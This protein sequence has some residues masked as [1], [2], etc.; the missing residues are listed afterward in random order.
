MIGFG[1]DN[2]ILLSGEE[3][4]AIVIEVTP[5]LIKYQK[6]SNLNGP[7]YTIF[8]KDVFL[9]K[10][11]NG[12]KDLFSLKSKNIET[13]EYFNQG[14]DAADTLHSA[15]PSFIGGIMFNWIGI[16]FIH[17]SDANRLPPVYAQEVNVMYQENTNFQKG[18]KQQARRKNIKAVWIGG[19]ISTVFY[20]VAA[21]SGN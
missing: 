15:G 20:I 3:I 17:A 10:Y 12:E 16:M 7:V 14:Q 2:I 18:Y 8:N 5:D 4:S 21:N 19:I 11:E 6:Y 13:F 9:I 1:Q